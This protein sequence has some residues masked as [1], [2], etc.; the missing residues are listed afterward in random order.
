VDD[1]DGDS[2]AARFV[3]IL[4]ASNFISQLHDNTDGDITRMFPMTIVKF[5]ARSISS[6]DGIGMG[7]QDAMNS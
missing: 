5:V 4:A 2:I 3:K 7:S 6:I 1:G